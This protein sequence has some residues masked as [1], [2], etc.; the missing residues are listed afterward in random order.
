MS[1]KNGTFLVAGLFAVTLAYYVGTRMS[2]EAINV[3]IGV[4]LG[5]IASVPVSLGLLVALTR[6]RER[7][8]DR[9][10]RTDLQQVLPYSTPRPQMPPVIVVAPPQG[11]NGYLNGQP[12]YYNPAA[13]PPY[14]NYQPEQYQEVVDGRDWRII[15]DDA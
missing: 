11:A 13:A 12:N 8:Y 1:A 10:V 5:M 14:V 15:G 3:A 6:Q 9:E 4:V 7:D 2:T